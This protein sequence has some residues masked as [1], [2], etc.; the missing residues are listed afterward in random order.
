MGSGHEDIICTSSLSF[1]APDQTLVSMSEA[2]SCLIAVCN[3][4]TLFCYFIAEQE[5]KM[6]LVI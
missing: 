4:L 2:L 6:S 5:N 3:L 1:E